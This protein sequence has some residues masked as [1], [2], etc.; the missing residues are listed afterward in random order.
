MKTGQEKIK[1][2]IINSS[3]LSVVEIR[4]NLTLIIRNIEEEINED[5]M[6]ATSS[7]RIITS[8]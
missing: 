2:A 8:R 3:L 1:A 5:N 6:V 7:T 4:K